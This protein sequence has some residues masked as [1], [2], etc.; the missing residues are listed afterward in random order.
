MDSWKKDILNS[1]LYTSTP[2]LADVNS[3]L[4]QYNVVLSDLIDK[5]APE[6]SRSITLCPNAPW[7]NDSLRAIKGQ[8]RKLERKYLSTRPEVH[9]QMYRDQY[10]IYTAALHSAK[11][12][13]YKAK[14]SESDNNQLFTMVDGLFKVKRLP[15]LPSHVSSR[16]LAEDFGE[17][18]RSKIEK[19]RDCLHNSNAQSTETS[20][21][22]NPSPCST[23]LSE[24][25]EVSETYIREL[26]DKSKPKSCCLDPVPTRIL[27]QSVDV[28]AQPITKVVNASLLVNFHL[29]SRKV[30]SI[31]QSI[32]K[33][34]LDQEQFTSY[35]PITNVVF[36]SKILER[37]VAS[38]TINYLTDNDLM[39]K[40]QSAY[41]RFH[42]TETALL[43]AC[44]N[45]ILLALDSRQKV[46][47]VLL[48]LPSAVDTID[49]DVLLDRLRSRYGIK[50]T[51][52]NW[53]RSYLTNRTQSVRIGDSSSSNRTLKY[54]V[55]QGSVLGPL[56]FSLFFC[57]YRRSDSRPRPA[58]Y[59]VRRRYPVIHNSQS[60]L[61]SSRHAV[62]T[63][64][65]HHRYLH[66]VHQQWTSL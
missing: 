9:R 36:L 13:Y 25:T 29:A 57:T 10:Q 22:I 8:R 51:A 5:H 46:V 64:I 44:I 56:L 3:L 61:R 37:V 18:F 52:L 50:R 42:S 12:T 41:R 26:T 15:P 2:D 55:P 35:R 39:S 4:D 32:K 62:Q 1:V 40:L 66:L 7:F 58:L 28:L 33:Q 53:F 19:I 31:H 59:G 30:L 21:L 63:P 11:L 34:T 54:G 14:I 47:L 27:K 48:D 6:C 45:D 17:I 65:V 49:H 20:V 16:S 38:Q 24:F 43:R 60:P 23:F